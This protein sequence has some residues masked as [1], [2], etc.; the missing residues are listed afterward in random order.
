MSRG[1]EDGSAGTALGGHAENL[2]L[3]PQPP[4]KELGMLV[5]SYNLSVVEGE[6]QTGGSLVLGGPPV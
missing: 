1:K 5:H 4:C 6:G 3:Y 2:T